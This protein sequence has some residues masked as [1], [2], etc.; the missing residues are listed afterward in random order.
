ML[1]IVAADGGCSGHGQLG[2]GKIGVQWVK[3]DLDRERSGSK[4]NPTIAKHDR[5]AQGSKNRAIMKLNR[6][7]SQPIGQ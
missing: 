3:G 7:K 5:A 6:F 1:L 2:N 4:I